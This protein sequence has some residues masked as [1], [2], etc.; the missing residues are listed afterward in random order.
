MS[1]IVQI[2]LCDNNRTFTFLGLHFAIPSLVSCS[3]N[4]RPNWWAVQY[5]R[6]FPRDAMLSAVYAVVVCL[7]VCLCVCLSHSGIVSKRLNVESRK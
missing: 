6:F 1:I 3:G 7:S 2:G 4:Y 5:G